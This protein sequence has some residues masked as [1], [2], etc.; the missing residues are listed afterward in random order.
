MNV[1][2]ENELNRN[3]S[4]IWADKYLLYVDACGGRGN[5]CQ[6]FRDFERVI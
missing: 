1:S 2:V 5:K 6:W 3:S 4:I